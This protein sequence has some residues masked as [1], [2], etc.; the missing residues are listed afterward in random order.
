MFRKATDEIA[1]AALLFPGSTAE[2]VQPEEFKIVTSIGLFHRRLFDMSY[3]ES[4]SV[5]SHIN[6]SSSV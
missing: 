4:T 5:I 6:N 3:S 2:N 1:G